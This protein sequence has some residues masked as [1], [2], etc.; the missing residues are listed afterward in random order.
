MPP[1]TLKR[2]AAFS[3]MSQT[4]APEQPI[5]FNFNDDPALNRT[6][7]LKLTSSTLLLEAGTW[8]VD[9]TVVGTADDGAAPGIP[10]I[11][12]GLFVNGVAYTMAAGLLAQTEVK[13]EDQ[14]CLTGSFVVQ[15]AEASSI[16][17]RNVSVFPLHFANSDD[18]KAVN[19][20]LLA[21][22]IAAPTPP[23]LFRLNQTAAIGDIPANEVVRVL[24]PRG[25]YLELSDARF[26]Q[27]QLRYT[28]SIAGP[29]PP[30]AALR[31]P[32]WTEPTR[33]E[34]TNISPQASGSSVYRGI[35]VLREDWSGNTGIVATLLWNMDTDLFSFFVTIPV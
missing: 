2:S 10:T 20:T 14:T 13:S 28:F 24:G 11:A 17:V 1:P 15:L 34:I 35:V 30:N 3:N 4:V 18:P 21:V 23:A 33:F 12:I 25:S 22:Q 26:S 29:W 8:T 27:S 5:H 31:Y 19:A 32:I 9:V 16:Q 7:R 6:R